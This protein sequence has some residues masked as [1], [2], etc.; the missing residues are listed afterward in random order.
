MMTSVS[1]YNPLLHTIFLEAANSAK[2]L[3]SPIVKALLLNG[4]IIFHYVVVFFISLLLMEVED[5]S[6]S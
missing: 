5:I 4:Y 6:N 3:G 1:G 2:L